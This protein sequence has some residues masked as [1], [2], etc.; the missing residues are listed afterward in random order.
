MKHSVPLAG[1]VSPCVRIFI[2]SLI[3]DVE[4][5]SVTWL[6]EPDRGESM[7]PTFVEADQAS[8]LIRLRAS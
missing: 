2:E 5:A 3:S 7:R 6:F 4:E 1:S 8:P